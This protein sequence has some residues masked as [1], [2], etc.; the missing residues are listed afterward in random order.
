[1]T[2]DARLDGPDLGPDPDA[3]TVENG[4]CNDLVH[5]K[6]GQERPEEKEMVDAVAS[7]VGAV[8]DSIPAVQI[9]VRVRPMLQWEKAEGYEASAMELKEGINGTVALKEDGRHRHFGFNAVIGGDRTQQ[10]VWEMSRL[11][12]VVRKVA[13]GFHATVFA[14][15]QTG[16][17]KTHTM[18]GFTY[19]HHCGIAPTMAAARPRVKA[20]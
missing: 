6:P 10:E 2:F 20:R 9:C 5:H 8:S 13:L 4:G 11:D 16:T 1:M 7:A 18:E 15:G 19:E 3:V 17:G 14:Y 12:A